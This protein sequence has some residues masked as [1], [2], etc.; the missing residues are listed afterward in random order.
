MAERI[1]AAQVIKT[2][3]SEEDV[4]SAAPKSVL[5]QETEFRTA[6]LGHYVDAPIPDRVA[7][8]W[9]YS[10]PGRF[11]PE[12][13][14][15]RAA[16]SDGALPVVSSPD[17][18]R[19]AGVDPVPLHT[20]SRG[21]ALLGRAVS[22]EFGLFEAMNGALFTAGMYIRIPRG[23]HVEA[24][25]Q[26]IHSADNPATLGRTVVELEPG[27]SAD[28]IEI[29][30]GGGEGVRSVTV[31]ELFVGE[32]ASLR[33]AVVQ[34]W[35]PKTGG[36]V[37][38]RA[39]V[40]QDGLFRETSLALGGTAYKCDLGAVLSG[41]GAESEIVGVSFADRKQHMDFHTVQHHAAER[42]QSQIRFKAALSGKANSA[43]TGLIRI[44][45]DAVLSEA[46]QENRALMLSDKA[47]AHAIPELEI[48]TDEVQCSHAATA[49]PLDD[50][51]LFYLMSRGISPGE[52]KRI[53]IRGFFTDALSKIPEP[54]REQA[55]IAVEERLARTF[56]EAG[57]V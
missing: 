40:E 16:D 37:T 22:P 25:I 54:L 29:F 6:C 18:L 31:S 35:A 36:I 43:Y 34:Q 28:V 24:P 53:L 38:V 51:E 1:R 30:E 11:F 3:V 57:A 4:R 26:I 39:K 17:V 8:L 9:R 21:L 19:E 44:E 42:T 41:I 2:A 14:P 27:A 7:H 50:K 48:M 49:S 47:R 45:D 23:R 15:R 12:G 46:N 52:A 56:K 5:Q 10:D 33:H 20:S 55:A 13:A 32:G